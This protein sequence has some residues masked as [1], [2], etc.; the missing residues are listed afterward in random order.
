[1]NPLELS[2]ELRRI[3]SAINNSANPSRELVTRD[4][5]HII[6]RL[7]NDGGVPAAPEKK[8]SKAQV[9]MAV[10]KIC[11]Q[12]PACCEAIHEVL[13]KLSSVESGTDTKKAIEELLA[14]WQH[15]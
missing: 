14:D 9:I 13:T 7:A 4:I 11:K 10:N 1:M 12:N 8:D 15:N 3:A 6:S 5:K 2:A